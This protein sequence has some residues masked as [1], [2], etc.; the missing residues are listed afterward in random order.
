MTFF[1]ISVF[2][3]C[4]AVAL[5]SALLSPAWAVDFT[6][7]S[8]DV[9][10]NGTISG[11][12]TLN[13]FGC[14][15]DNVSPAL[16]WSGAPVGTKSFAVTVYDPDAP[17]GSGFWHWLVVNLPADAKGIPTGA[18]K[19]GSTTLPAGAL[20]TRTDFGGPGYGGPCPPQGDAPHHYHFTV[21]AVDVDRLPVDETASGAIVGFN[22]HFHTLAQARFVATY[23]R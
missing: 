9:E 17:T 16:A 8:P 12:F 1:N 7:T 23:G 6:L 22:L 15:G 20:Q 21:F 2:T 19:Q 10:A 14:S 4:A 18:G 13:G 3:A 5:S 11:K